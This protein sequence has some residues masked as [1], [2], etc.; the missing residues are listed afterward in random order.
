MGINKSIIY[1]YNNIDNNNK[2]KMFITPTVAS[3]NSQPTSVSSYKKINTFSQKPSINQI[4]IYIV[5]MCQIL[6][7]YIIIQHRL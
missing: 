3:Q 4:I 5:S 2:Y 7:S 6:T 1:L